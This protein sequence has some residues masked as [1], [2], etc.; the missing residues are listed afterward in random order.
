MKTFRDLNTVQQKH[1]CAAAKEI[2]ITALLNKQYPALDTD[3]QNPLFKKINAF[4]ELL[5]TNAGDH[6][7][8]RQRRAFK[9]I[10]G[11]ELNDLAQEVATKGLYP[12]IT[13][14]ILV[15]VNHLESQ[16]MAIYAGER[17]PNP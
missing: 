12:E 17:H 14:T 15:R 16:D 6:G 9:E 10:F 7:K 3:K 11:D 13:D 1:A 2:L 5:N 4:L 8:N